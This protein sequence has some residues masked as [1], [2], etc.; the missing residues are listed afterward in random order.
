MT[1]PTEQTRGFVP[2][3]PTSEGTEAAP[4]DLPLL[5]H[6]PE[7]SCL[8]RQMTQPAHDSVPK[9]NNLLPPGKKTRGKQK[10]ETQHIR[11]KNKRYTTFYKRKE[12]LLKKAVEL[13]KLTSAEVLVLVASETRHVYSYATPTFRPIA[14]SQWG[15]SLTEDCLDSETPAS[16]EMPTALEHR[17]PLITQPG[18]ALHPSHPPVPMQ[19]YPDTNH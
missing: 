2:P 15:Y 11:D 19:S 8:M 13:A 10:I 14:D 18:P 7:T 12:G 17:A 9:P 1:E 3:A 16:D 4:S 5:C 6:S